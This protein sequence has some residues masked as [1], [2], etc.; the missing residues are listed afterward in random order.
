VGHYRLSLSIAFVHKGVD[1]AEEVESLLSGEVRIKTDPPYLNGS[2]KVRHPVKSGDDPEV[3]FKMEVGPK[4][5]RSFL[6]LEY[7]KRSS[8]LSLGLESEISL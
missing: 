7:E 2:L 5:F 4:I 3:S 1:A 6:L 8:H